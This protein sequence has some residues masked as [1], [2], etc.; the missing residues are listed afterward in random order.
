MP[1]IRCIAVIVVE[2]FPKQSTDLRH[3][4]HVINTGEKHTPCATNISG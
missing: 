1:E 4:R 3:K 2:E